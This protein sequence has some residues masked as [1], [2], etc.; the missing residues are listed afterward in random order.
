MFGL[1]LLISITRANELLDIVL[2]GRPIKEPF[3]LLYSGWYASMFARGWVVDLGKKFS[4]TIITGPKLKSAYMAK[5]ASSIGI[6]EAELTK[7]QAK[8]WRLGHSYG[9]IHEAILN[10]CHPFRKFL[11][12][13]EEWVALKNRQWISGEIVMS[14]HIMYIVIIAEE[15]RTQ[16][17]CSSKNLRLW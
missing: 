7:D 4:S 3:K 16:F 14:F 13:L 5:M 12:D 2:Q 10:F 11:G 8:V 15:F 1:M 17:D 6:N 9:V